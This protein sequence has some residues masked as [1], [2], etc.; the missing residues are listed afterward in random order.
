MLRVNDWVPTNNFGPPNNSFVIPSRFGP[1]GALYMARW[2]FG[3]CRNQLTAERR[4]RADQDRVRARR[5]TCTGDIR[6][7]R[8]SR[9]RSR[10]TLPHRIAPNTYRNSATLSLTSTDLGCSGRGHGPSTGSNGGDWTAYTA[11][12]AVREPRVRYTVEYRATDRAGNTSRRRRAR[13]VHGARRRAA[14]RSRAATTF[15]EGVVV[16]SRSAATSRSAAAS[17]GASTSRTRSSRTTSGSCG[18][19][20]IRTRPAETW[21]R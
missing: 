17:R 7:R 9:A 8:P 18:R 1:D 12:G 15:A 6:R 20:A 5:T 16:G 10:A 11:P 19:A 4:D 21:S 2:S 13:H 14:R 3:C